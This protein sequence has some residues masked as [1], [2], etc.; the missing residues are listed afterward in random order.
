M[1]RTSAL[2]VAGGAALLACT[3]EDAGGLLGSGSA[4]P[5]TSGGP[6]RMPVESAPH[7]RTFMSWPPL[8]S[9]WT[10][11]DGP[12]VQDDIAG[13]ARAIAQFEPVTILAE[14]AEADAAQ[15]ACGSGVEVVPIATDDL[16]MRDSGPTFVIGPN[17][18]AGIDM[19][20]NGWGNKQKH[21]RD[22]LV[23]SALL[24]RLNVPRID[25]PIVGE[26]GSI[27]IDGEG[28]LMATES[29]LVNSN[30]NPG[31]SRDDIERALKELTGVSKV[32]WVKG[33]AG[34]DIT[35]YHIDSLA[36][37]AE[38]GVVIISQAPD[39]DDVW[40]GAYK[41]ALGVLQ[42]ETDAKGRKLEIVNLPEPDPSN[43]GKRGD[44]FLASYVNFYVVNGGVIMPKFG[45]S[46]ADD[47]AKGIVADLHPGRTVVQI[48][49]NTVAEG[50]GGI[51]CSTQQQPAV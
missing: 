31:K 5:V 21:G 14:P 18:L 42:N 19:H 10:G 13:I 45:D 37:F 1:F 32:I 39:G 23:A 9:V 44:A 28:T 49:I 46:A 26:G 33:V 3:P 51:H 8:G 17:G 24:T 41:Q 15:Q 4:A 22:A 50:G 48:E 35:D 2:A 40:S 27:E 43:I 6:W 20:F 25:A 16:W 47:H 7:A 38:P 11:Q 34:Q 29:S 30:R 12:G 36:R